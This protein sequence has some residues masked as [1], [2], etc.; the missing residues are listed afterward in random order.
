MKLPRI[1]L[2]E[3]DPAAQLVIELTLRQRVPCELILCR[4]E[5]EMQ[6]QL[7]RH[8]DMALMIVD[9]QLPD[10]DG[11]ALIAE[12]VRRYPQIPVIATASARDERQVQAVMQAGAVDYLRK[13]DDPA[14]MATLI[15]AAMRISA[16]AMAATREGDPFAGIIGRSDALAHAIE[17]ARQAAE[18]D[19]PVL[20]TGESG[21]GKERMAQAIHEAGPRVNRPFVA[22]NCGA[23]PANLVESTLF[24]HVKGA[25]TGAMADA[26]GK[27]READGGTLFLDEVGE[28]PPDVQ[29][30][31]LRVLQEQEVQPVGGGAPMPVD[32]RI[33]S[34][35]HV[36][37]ERAI[38][39]GRFREDLFYRLHV[40][41]IE[42]PPL[43]ARGKIDIV[44]LIRHFIERFAA[45]EGKE[46]D[47]IT[48]AAVGLLTSYGWP[49]NIRQLENAVYR[50]VVLARETRLKAED[51]L[52]ISNALQQQQY[53]TQKREAAAPLP[54]AES[55]AQTHGTDRSGQTLYLLG[56]G[57]DF[58]SLREIET[59]V[60]QKA[61]LH[62]RWRITDIAQALGITRA[63]VYKKMREAG[64]HDPRKTG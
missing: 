9:L 4:Y 49:G 52:Q 2:A 6:E 57:G 7:Q 61:L 40:F 14:R 1:L 37:L 44:M 34:A 63:T 30:S 62:Y 55:A 31:L 28:L 50:A 58:R 22:V 45:Q 25:F 3:N 16:P 38:A 29:V 19:I 48:E 47:G 39:D 10:A 13:S 24:G 36:D 46:V 32:I 54:D 18:S 8:P 23:I 15:Q 17:Q 56:E 53:S 59:E 43:R 35:T 60:L 26:P 33:I 27:F 51:F 12:L 41:P 64:L 5:Y 11:V 21:T 42:V 20:I